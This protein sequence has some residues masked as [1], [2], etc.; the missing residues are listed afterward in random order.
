MIHPSNDIVYSWGIHE[1]D[2]HNNKELYCYIGT[3]LIADKPTEDIQG[4]QQN[5]TC[6]CT[7]MRE[8]NLYEQMM[9]VRLVCMERRYTLHDSSRHHTQRIKDRYWKDGDTKSY[10]T[11]IREVIGHSRSVIHRVKC[12]NRH[13]HT[14]HQRSTISYEHLRFFT[15]H[16]M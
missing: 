4:I 7:Y 2:E 1:S 12:E 6:R 11:H 3:Q 9:Q 8:A 5:H 14:H 13:Q 10:H 16:V 15:E